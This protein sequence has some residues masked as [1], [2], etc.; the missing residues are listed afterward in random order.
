MLDGYDEL[1]NKN[2]K[3]SEL[4]NTQFLNYSIIR[5]AVTTRPRY[6]T[7]LEINEDFSKPDKIYICPF[8]KD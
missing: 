4:I 7:D 5:I 8:N 1:N 2:L 3:I 6:A